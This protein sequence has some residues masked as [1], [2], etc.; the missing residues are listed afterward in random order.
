[1]HALVVTKV[2]YCNSVLSSI[3]GQLLQRLQSVFNATA[4]LS[5]SCFFHLRQ[6]R[7]ITQSLTPTVRLDYCNSLLA[8][9]S[10]R[11]LHRM[12]VVQNLFIYFI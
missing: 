11:L 7:S 12:Q 5:L 6:L 2:D 8:D 10:N 4:A 1:V 3:P 9:V